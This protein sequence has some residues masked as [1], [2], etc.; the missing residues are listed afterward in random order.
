[1]YK[2]IL[3]TVDSSGASKRALNE[4]LSLASLTKGVVYVV[5]I[6]SSVVEGL[7]EE[8]VSSDKLKIEGEQLL[9]SCVKAGEKMGVM[10][11]KIPV[12]TGIPE[13]VIKTVTAEKGI[14]IIIMGS[15]GRKGIE[16]LTLGSVAEHVVRNSRVP[17]MCL[18]GDKMCS[19]NETG[20]GIGSGSGPGIGTGSG[21]GSGKGSGTSGKSSGTSGTGSGNTGLGTT[22]SGTSGT[23]SGHQE[24]KN[25]NPMSKILVPYDGSSMSKDALTHIVLP[26]AKL[27]PH[28]HLYL[29]YH[30]DT[31]SAMMEDSINKKKE[32][33]EKFL[34]EAKVQVG[35]TLGAD[36]VSA[37]LAVEDSHAAD[38]ISAFAASFDLL[39]MPTNARGNLTR[40][41]MGSVTEQVLRQCNTPVLVINPTCLQA[42]QAQTK[43]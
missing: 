28:S 5:H 10:I 7:K 17:V 26:F 8:M 30:L 32:A 2:K 12:S 1:M 33:A 20:S 35:N 22:G 6:V 41:F 42:A 21:T 37:D 18:R 24:R 34:N 38:G 23:G 3:V 16:K 39:I 13:E 25:S 36:R 43:S 9:D 27:F 40:M 4:G 29:R 31:N 19:S 15:H 14:D 11:E